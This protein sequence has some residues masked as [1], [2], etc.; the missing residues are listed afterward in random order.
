MGHLLLWDHVLWSFLLGF[1]PL[2]LSMGWKLVTGV[3]DLLWYRDSQTLEQVIRT[4]QLCPHASAS[5]RV[6]VHHFPGPCR[7]RHFKSL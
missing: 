7:P 4:R 1:T 6:P 3:A 2:A 5:Y